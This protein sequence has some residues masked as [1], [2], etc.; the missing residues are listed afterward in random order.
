MPTLE[1]ITLDGTVD[2]LKLSASMIKVAKDLLPPE[3]T[4]EMDL[5]HLIARN[6]ELAEKARQLTDEE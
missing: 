1:Q 3:T 5:D 6:L 2:T 4:C